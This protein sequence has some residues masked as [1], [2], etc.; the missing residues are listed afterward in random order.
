MD[1]SDDQ[2]NLIV[3]RVIEKLGSHASTPSAATKPIARTSPSA[4]PVAP[5]DISLGRFEKI[6]D[7]INAAEKA[8]NEYREVTIAT[9][10]RI[11]AA[12]RN[13]CREHVGELARMA[14][15]ETKMGRV[16]DKIKK[17]LLAINKTPG[18]EDLRP[19]AFT[20]DDGLTLLE[21]APWGVIGSVTPSTNP[22][23]T[24]ISNS[25]GMIAG[26]NTVVFNTHP[27]AR[28]VSNYA[29]HLINKAIIAEG[30]PAN[31]IVT[32]ASPTIESAQA[33]MKH[34]GIRLLVVTG[35]PAVVAQAMKSGKRVIGAGPGNPPVVVD[36]TADI[37]AAGR[38]IVMSAGTDNNIVCTVE[39]EII[40]TEAAAEDL[41]RALIK[42]GA[43]EIHA[44]QAR[45]LEGILIKN[46]HPNKDFVGRDIQVILR[47]I[48]LEVE[49]SKRIAII[50]TGPDH[51]FAV[52]EMLMP[53][54]SFIRVKNVDDAIDLAYKLEG[55]C[56]HTSV[57]HSRNI[58]SLNKMHMKMNTSIFV[59]NGPA[60]A[61][62]GME[63]EGSTSFTIASPTGDGV[64]TPKSFTRL[65]KCVMSG[66]F[67]RV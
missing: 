43:V 20:G 18:T 23:E 16:E 59:K 21:R 53:I 57:M 42:H 32:V 22:T 52:T 48:G 8:F 50:E 55:G 39:K 45:R 64:T 10:D 25:I 6:D 61:G 14:V 19:T 5:V 62:L 2:I 29:V 66:H 65:R 24:V 54:L 31:L 12:I 38:D 27:S 11:I 35:G 9:R 1:T 17:N 46:G 40:V 51:P 13:I 41:K 34:P 56:F 58:D 67:G 3:D 26:G 60:L 63:G 33:L 47:E 28:K 30:G 36:E 4:R 37:D 7:A 44:A 15:E 49:A